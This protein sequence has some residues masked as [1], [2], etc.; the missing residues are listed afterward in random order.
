[1][2]GEEITS[3]LSMGMYHTN[4][5]TGVEGS[6]RGW[7]RGIEGTGVVLV[8][9]GEGKGAFI[10]SFFTFMEMKACDRFAM[11]KQVVLCCCWFGR[12]YFCFWF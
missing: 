5:F 9:V 3:G 1:M 10:F 12:C 4:S 7:E 11:E 8:V 6:L 2:Y